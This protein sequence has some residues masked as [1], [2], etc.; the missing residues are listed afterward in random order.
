MC[1]V[2]KR[3]CI[4]ACIRMRWTERPLA[5]PTPGRPTLPPDRRRDAAEGVFDLG[6]P[7]KRPDV[8]RDDREDHLFVGHVALGRRASPLPFEQRHGI[9]SSS[10]RTWTTAS[11]AAQVDRSLRVWVKAD[12]RG[13]LGLGGQTLLGLHRR[14]AKASLLETLSEQ[15]EASVGPVEHLEPIPA[16]ADEDEVGAIDVLLAEM[17][18]AEGGES[19]DALGEVHWLP[20]DQDSRRRGDQART[21]KRPRRR[22]KSVSWSTRTRASRCL[23]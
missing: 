12:Q 23:K 18:I 13:G 3:A 21:P 17:D 9:P 2:A 4:A 1:S 19:G 15:E 6:P 10:T 8:G 11:I 20:G 7:R 5:I 22:S 16:P 14:P